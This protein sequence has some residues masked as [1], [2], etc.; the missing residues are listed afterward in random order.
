MDTSIKAFDLFW[1]L[2]N[3]NSHF[4]NIIDDGFK[5]KQI[6]FFNEEELNKIRNQNFIHPTN[7]HIKEFEDIFILGQNIG[8]C[9]GISRQL[10]YSYNDIDLVS[11]ILP[12]LKGTLNAEQL[13]GHAWLESKDKIIDTSLMLVIDASLKETFGYQEENR[14]TS[15]QLKQ[16]RNYQTRKEFTNDL[17]LKSKKK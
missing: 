6:R 9:V 17:N 1:N 5:N 15:S 3:N 10:S 12:F 2:Y 8:N 16:D 11:G 4:K 7:P 14:I 13:G